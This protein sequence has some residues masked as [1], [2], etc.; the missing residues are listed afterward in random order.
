MSFK[1]PTPKSLEGT[2]IR[3]R[4][5]FS[6]TTDRHDSLAIT[7]HRTRIFAPLTPASLVA[8]PQPPGDDKRRST[9]ARAE[10]T[11]RK[12]QITASGP[13]PDTISAE[14]HHIR[15]KA[16]NMSGEKRPASF[17]STQLVKRA[18]PDVNGN[19]LATTNG[20]AGGALIKGVSLLAVAICY[21]SAR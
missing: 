19:E 6:S 4:P 11:T 10:R 17:G 2:I 16:Y 12:K 20:P 5:H 13:I 15:D 9:T 14:G 8:T 1:L 18:R 21:G 7:R 3:R